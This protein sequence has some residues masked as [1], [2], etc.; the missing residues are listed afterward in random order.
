MLIGIKTLSFWL[1]HLTLAITVEF[2]IIEHLK[3]LAMEHQEHQQQLIFQI[4]HRTY[5]CMA[6][7][8]ETF[9]YLKNPAYVQLY[10]QKYA[11]SVQG[12]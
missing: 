10:E 7:C 3:D 2:G 5:C 8:V 12:L 4:Q 9:S 6:L 1:L 11:Q